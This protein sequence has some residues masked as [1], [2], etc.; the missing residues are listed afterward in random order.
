MRHQRGST[1]LTCLLLWIGEALIACV[2]LL[3]VTR[4]WQFYSHTAVCVPLPV[5]KQTFA[6][7]RYTFGVIIVLNFLLFVS[8]QTN[9]AVAMD[10]SKQAQH[11]R[12]A[13]CLI[14][15]ALS[16][17]MCWFPVGLLGLL[18]SRGYHIPGEVNAVLVILVLPLNPALNPFLYTVNTLLEGRQREKERQLLLVK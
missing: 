8:V 3:P 9:R 16:D 2:P 13:R 15:I 14:T 18:A 7:H 6:G 11:V 17:F 1:H 4:H 10:S 5:T 12:V